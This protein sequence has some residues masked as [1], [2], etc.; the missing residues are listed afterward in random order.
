M[1][2]GSYQRDVDPEVYSCAFCIV[3]TES[4]RCISCAWVERSS[5]ASNYRGELLGALGYLLILKAVFPDDRDYIIDVSTLPT[6]D[7]YCDNMGVVKHGRLPMKPLSEKQVQ[8]D[9]L[10]HI[11]YLLRVLP[12]RTRFNH[13]RAHMRRV[14]AVKDM[15]LEQVLNEEMDIKAGETLVDAVRDGD[16]ITT[17]FP[18]E[19]ITMKC[20]DKRVTASATE[21]IYDWEGQQTAM[22]LFE[23]K[24]IVS[25]DLFYN[26]YWEGF[27]KVMT[28]RFNSSFATFYSKHM[29]RCCGV[30]H[31]L[32]Y[33]D[34]SIPDECPCCGSPGETTAHI[35]LCPD[36]TV[37]HFTIGQSQI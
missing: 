29:I 14:L 33:I 2:D 7:A 35:A 25:K 27:G 24:N 20:G 22:A 1:S 31:H 19:R 18:H 3:C 34:P 37:L 15:T 12:A 28:K 10:G 8:S 6:S 23:E 32:H 21:A 16:Y 36:K 17:F 13:V 5:C 9:I 4:F 11:K 30:R 26:I